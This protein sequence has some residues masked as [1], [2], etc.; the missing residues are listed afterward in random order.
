MIK[1][2]CAPDPSHRLGY[3]KEGL[4]GVRKHRWFEGFDWNSLQNETMKPPVIPNIKNLF[5]F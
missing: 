3:Q 1:S 4:M 2:L 5:N